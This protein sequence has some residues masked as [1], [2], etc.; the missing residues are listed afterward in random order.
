MV[1]GEYVAH[2]HGCLLGDVALFKS[3]GV[4]HSLNFISEHHES[5]SMNRGRR[6]AID[7]RERCNCTHKTMSTDYRVKMRVENQTKLQISN[8]KRMSCI[9]C[10][11]TRRSFHTTHVVFIALQKK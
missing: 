6:C 8:N 3:F 9:L 5:W 1:S 11:P 2:K 10:G 4:D 7:G